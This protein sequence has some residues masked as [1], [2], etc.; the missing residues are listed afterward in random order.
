LRMVREMGSAVYGYEVQ[1]LLDADDAAVAGLRTRLAELGD[2]LVVVGV[3][4]GTWKVHVH[5]NDVGAALEAGLAAGRP[6]QISVTRLVEPA[7]A[8]GRDIVAVAAT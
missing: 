8:G 1:Y 6:H 5:V 3:G 7:A 4:D 2:S